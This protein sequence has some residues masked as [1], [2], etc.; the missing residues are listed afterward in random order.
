MTITGTLT[1]LN[2]ALKNLTFTPTTGYTGAASIALGYTDVGNGLTAPA[3]IAVTVGSGGA[4]SIGGSTTSPQTAVVSSPS[5]A[6]SSGDETTDSDTQ[7]AGFAAA[8]E[9]LNS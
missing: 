4:A 2:N 1:N 8:L 5:S 6:D 7:W 3:N 9:T